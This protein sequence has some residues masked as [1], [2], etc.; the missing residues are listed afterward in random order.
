MSQLRASAEKSHPQAAERQPEQATEV[1]DHDIKMESE[2]ED[3]GDTEAEQVESSDEA[4]ETISEERV[5]A[6]EEDKR[7]PELQAAP[8][9]KYPF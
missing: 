5:S 1:R 8:T 2:V 7:D 9:R 3:S 4:V 6:D